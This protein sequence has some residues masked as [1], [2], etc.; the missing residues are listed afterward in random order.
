MTVI[1]TE[2]ETETETA[3]VMTETEDMPTDRRLD[4][5]GVLNEEALL[6]E[7]GPAVRMIETEGHHQDGE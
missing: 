5:T 3:S 4:E 6:T 1:E 2:T 7:I